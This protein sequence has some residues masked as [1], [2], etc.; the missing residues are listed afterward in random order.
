MNTVIGQFEGLSVNS[1]MND[2]RSIRLLFSIDAF[3]ATQDNPVKTAA[4][5]ERSS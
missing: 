1:P 4:E 5:V 3:I 2:G